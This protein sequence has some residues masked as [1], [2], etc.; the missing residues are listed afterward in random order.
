MKKSFIYVFVCTL[1]VAFATSCGNKTPE[2]NPEAD[3]LRNVLNQNLAEMDEMSLFLDAVNASMDS[4]VNM[5]QEVLKT[6]G[7]RAGSKKDQIR[8]NIAAYKKILDRQR[9]RLAVLEKK[10]KDSNFKSDKLLQTVESLKKQI[11]EKD[12]AIVELTAELEKRNVDIEGLKNNVVR[13][14]TDL[15]Q[16][17]EDNKAKDQKIEAQTNTMN[18][19][20]YVIGTKKELQAAG[21]MSEG[22]IFKKSKLD[23]SKA[24]ASA[25]KKIDIRNTF[26]FSIPGKKPQVLTQ[27]PN[28]SYSLTVNANGT[29]TLTITD[30]AKFW[31]ITNHL[32][33]RY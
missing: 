26:S 16:A 4:V 9:E 10:L 12:Q 30:A 23:M 19:A 25:F 3:S 29:S 27:H 1:I 24:S 28:G 14:T 31:S 18:E 6:S 13:L 15:A 2:G 20:F 5:E 11:E 22:S 32:V 17:T 8:Q 7:E 21:L 33:V